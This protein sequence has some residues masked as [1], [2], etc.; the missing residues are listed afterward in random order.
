[1]IV[2]LALC[3]LS[4]FLGLTVLMP[5]LISLYANP[6]TPTFSINLFDNQDLNMTRVADD[7]PANLT[8]NFDLKL[9]NENSAIGPLLPSSSRDY[10][11]IL[12]KYI[13]DGYVSRVQS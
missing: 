3:C 8:I 6:S 13:H 5:V 12:P 7:S 9:K 2:L 1:M 11:F 10:I 4:F